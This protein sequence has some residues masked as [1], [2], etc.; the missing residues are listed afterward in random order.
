MRVFILILISIF[1]ANTSVATAQTQTSTIQGKITDTYGTP[2]LGTTILLKESNHGTVADVNGNYNIQVANNKIITLQFSYVGFKTVNRTV[3]L[4]NGEIKTINIQLEEDAAALDEVSIKSKSEIRIKREEAYAINVINA[5]EL[6]NSGAD[7]NKVLDR[8]SGVRVRQNGGLGSDFTFSL[9]GFSGRQVKFFLDGIPIDNFGSSLTLNNYP[10]NLA[11]RIE[12]YKGVLPISLGSDALGGAVNIVT[13]DDA[14]YLDAS[15]GFGALNTHRASVNLAYT[16]PKNGFTAKLISFY[17]YSDNNYKVKVRPIDLQTN[18]RLPEQEVERFHDDYESA[19]AQVEIG[20]RD[21]PYA[22][23][24]LLGFIASGNDKQIQTGV[25]MNQVFGARTSNSRA[26]IPTL[27]YSK[28]NLFANG[29]DVK[30]YGVYNNTRNRFIDTTRVRYNWLGENIPSTQ[31]EFSRTQLENKDKELLTTTNVSYAIDENYGLSINYL[32]TDFK[33]TSSDVENPN[34]PTLQFPQSLTKNIL[35]LAYQAKLERFTGTAFAKAYFLNAETFVSDF[36]ASGET[37]F[38]KTN[39]NTDNYGFGAA[40]SYF[41]LPKL[42]AKTSYEHTYRLP[43]PTELL[44]DGLFT[45]RNSNLKPETSDNL[46]IGVKYEFN[47][48]EVNTISV[49]ANYLLRK[50]K[51]FIRLDQSVS[52]PV[53]RQFVNLGDVV[54]NGFEIDVQYK[55]KSNLRAGLNLT[56]QSIIDKQEFL[57]SSNLGGT[58]Q[59]PNFNYGFKVPNIPYLYGNANVD[60]TFKKSENSKSQFN[61]GYSLNY[62]EEYFFTP[63]QIGANNQD[64]IPMQLS[65]NL[66]AGYS[67]ADGKFNISLALDNI[68]NEDLF[69]NY[70][71]QKP[72]RSFFLNL[73]YYIDKPF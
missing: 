38:E 45:T 6:Y 48:V 31:A 24:L 51:D 35:G 43:Q 39:S 50:S 7:I 33:R 14:N 11:K 66:R 60:Y 57:S 71:L 20:V 37:Q 64:N 23:K 10:V 73:R 41:I 18:Q 3:D 70:L 46:N 36:N 25:T 55:Y 62:V 47:V 21:K 19:T 15:Y 29:L 9:N 13:R 68:T 44:G 8:T 42:Q 30:F 5:K 59:S 53:A 4:Q 28:E 40:A 26:L 61:I 56:Y 27:K 67:L 52:Q 12:I 69:D 17:N 54:T 1:V 16:N 63:N 58:T 72:G 49:E 2:L 65:H 34:S 32:F 22:D